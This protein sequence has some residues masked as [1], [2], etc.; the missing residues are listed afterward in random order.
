MEFISFEES[1]RI[2]HKS[3]KTLNLTQKVFTPEALGRVLAKDI[4]AK[5][6]S[7]KFKTAAMD[8]Y[9][10]RWEDQ[11]L[12]RLKIVDLVPAGSEAKKRIQKGE[13][14]KTFTGSLMCEGSDTLIPIE[15]VEVDGDYIVIKE[16]VSK[17]FSVRPVG[18][19]YK[20]GEVLIKKGR[21]ISFADI[22]VLASLNEVLVEVYKSPVISII[23]TGSEI[24]DL[25]EERKNSSQIYSSN[26]YTLEAIAKAE[27]A[28]VIRVGC[29]GDNKELIK[30]KIIQ[31]IERSDIVVTTGGVSVG[32]FDFVKEILNSMEVNYLIKGV[33]IKPG[34][35][36][37][38]VKVKEKFIVALPGFPYSSTVTFFLYVVPII[39]KMQGLSPTL[40]VVLATLREDYKKRSKKEEFTAVNISYE[41]GE[42]FVDLQG[43]K[44][45]SSAILT[46]MLSNTALMRIRENDGDKK[47]GERVEV[48]LFDLEFLRE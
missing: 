6:N 44:S 46:N 36:I 41:N 10:I 45:G 21:K 5:E 15:N 13:C 43:K 9:A 7:P 8:G 30:E 34:Q 33:V 24:L 31:S 17:G 2:L 35:H 47:R 3:I 29:V 18:E 32:D 48:I 19:N 12:K 37:K 27:G 42:F 26:H 40:P 11:K 28:E 39:R 22:G 1:M 16:E 14:V 25:G 23:A 20:K 38:I 4:V